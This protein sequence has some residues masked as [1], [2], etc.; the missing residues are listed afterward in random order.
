MLVRRHL[1]TGITVLG[2]ATAAFFVESLFPLGDWR[3]LVISVACY[4]V[5]WLTDSEAPLRAAKTAPPGVIRVALAKVIHE[6]AE[7]ILFIVFVGGGAILFGFFIWIMTR[8]PL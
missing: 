4:L 8:E 3:W 6:Q 1:T 7:T 5:A 2:T